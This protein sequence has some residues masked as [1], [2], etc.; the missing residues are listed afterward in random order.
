MGLIDMRRMGRNAN[1]F[2]EN[3]PATT[4]PIIV[5][6]PLLDYSI[7]RPRSLALAPPHQ[8]HVDEPVQVL[9]DIEDVDDGLQTPFGRWIAQHTE[10]SQVCRTGWNKDLTPSG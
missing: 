4:Q 3:I 8:R 7:S 1:Q 5:T 9:L 6:V 2:G 10:P